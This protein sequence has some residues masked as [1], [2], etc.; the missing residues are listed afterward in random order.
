VA[1]YR[2]SIGEC[3]LAVLADGRVAALKLES[4]DYELATGRASKFRRDL[5]QS[6]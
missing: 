6:E 3:G 1:A 5:G 2:A 4:I